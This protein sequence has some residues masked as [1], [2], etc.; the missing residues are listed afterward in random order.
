MNAKHIFLFLSLSTFYCID[1]HAQSVSDSLWCDR[2]NEIVKCASIETITDRIAKNVRDSDYI[3]AF[4]PA[5]TITGDPK[6][7]LIK[8][9][10]FKVTYVGYFYSSKKNDEKLIT[11]FND[12][13]TK[14]KA[15]LSLWD[16]ARLKNSDP[17]L[18]ASVPEDYFITNGED[19]TTLRL[20]ITYN[21]ETQ[22]YE[23][24]LRIY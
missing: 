14:I 3:A 13:Y 15:C 21:L 22:I 4:T 7:E 6:T 19:E 10:Y 18:Q 23:V 17:T 9:Q 5:L 2:L 1:A 16:S 20:D 24:R 11:A 12:T 8:K